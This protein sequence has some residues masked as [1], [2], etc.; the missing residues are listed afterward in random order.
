MRL[1][2][3]INTINSGLKFLVS[4]VKSFEETF[5]SP[6]FFNPDKVQTYSSSHL[7]PLGLVDHEE[8]SIPTSDGERLDGYYFKSSEKTDKTVIFFHG[9]TG[10]IDD[11]YPYVVHMQEEFASIKFPVNALIFD[12]RAYGRSTG[13]NPTRLNIHLDSLGAVDFLKRR[14]VDVKEM[15]LI[16]HSN[17]AAIAL[18]LASRLYKKKEEVDSVVLL[19]PYLSPKAATVETKGSKGKYL[20]WFVSNRYLNPQ[21]LVKQIGKIPL[22]VIHSTKDRYFPLEHGVQVFSTSNSTSEFLV[23]GS[24]HMPMLDEIGPYELS[25]V[26]KYSRLNGNG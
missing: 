21:R 24:D 22:T 10:N 5:V 16:G 9:R 1:Q 15:I 3:I 7:R 18:D 2:P 4:P 19:A 12:Y 6:C 11:Y 20:Q 13:K 14:G 8:V 25:H 26:A 17:G 23:K